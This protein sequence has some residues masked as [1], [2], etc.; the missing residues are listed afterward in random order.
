MKATYLLGLPR[1]GSLA[2]S[3][4]ADTYNCLAHH[5]G[6]DYKHVI[7]P[8]MDYKD[9][10]SRNRY[11]MARDREY[12]VTGEDGKRDIIKR[13]GDEDIKRVMNYFCCDTSCQENIYTAAREYY[14]GA[15]IQLLYVRTCPYM[16]AQSMYDALGGML[17]L[18]TLINAMRYLDDKYD[19]FVVENACVID[20]STFM[21]INKNGDRFTDHQWRM[22]S[23]FVGFS[24][25]DLLDPDWIN[26]R[27]SLTT[28]ELI[29]G[30]NEAMSY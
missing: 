9:Y 16:A 14:P 24:L 8:S 3:K 5:E 7:I 25:P 21:E 23:E 13:D 29:R 1:C 26:L 17:E 22:M 19:K 27:Y 28:E 6:G 10:H 20:P 12:L 18:S 11:L 15:D 2:L 30:V 4:I